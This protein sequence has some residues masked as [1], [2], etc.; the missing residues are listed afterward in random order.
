MGGF[1]STGWHALVFLSVSSRQPAAIKRSDD[2]C[3]SGQIL[4]LRTTTRR[5]QF[6]RYLFREGVPDD[7]FL[8][9]AG[10]YLLFVY[11]H[12]SWQIFD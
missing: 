3:L 9:M 6:G 4:E 5:S 8:S 11:K 12:M 1:L 7:T 10:T 2:Y